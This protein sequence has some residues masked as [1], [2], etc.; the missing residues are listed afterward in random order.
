MENAPFEDVF[1]YFLLRRISLPEWKHDFLMWHLKIGFGSDI[2]FWVLI[3]FWVFFVAQAFAKCCEV[4]CSLYIIKRLLLTKTSTFWTFECTE[5]QVFFWIHP[6]FP[7]PLHWHSSR[8][9]AGFGRWAHAHGS[10][11]GLWRRCASE[12]K[13]WDGW[14]LVI[15]GWPLGDFC[16]FVCFGCFGWPHQVFFCKETEYLRVVFCTLDVTFGHAS[17]SFF[18]AIRMYLHTK[19]H[20]QRIFLK[21]NEGVEL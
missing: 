17:V 7:Q 11:Q 5:C 2:W 4:V 13:R 6:P 14:H 15:V 3:E 16:L 20:N 9:D 19:L 1:L 18:L 21:T 8:W 10:R 12:E